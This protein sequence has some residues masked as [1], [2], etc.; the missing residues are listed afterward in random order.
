MNIGIY[1]YDQAEV[2]DFSGPFEVFTTASRVS[3]E[4]APFSVFLI[5]EKDG[6]VT[7]RAGYQVLPNATIDNHP[8]I[9]VLIIVGGVHTGEMAN[10]KVKVWIADQAAIVQQVATVC[11]G[12]FLFANA[13]PGLKGRVTTHWDDQGDLRTQFPQLDVVED[14][15]WVDDGGVI[16][17]GGISAGID[18]CLH[19]VAKLH[20][21]ELAEKTARQMEYRWDR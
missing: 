12:I 14:V 7:A 8:P 9:D 19:L 20:S 4:D 13:Q 6:P 21:T 1:I 10:E 11:T 5:A 16:S 18:M 3:D 17:S 2:L 15:R